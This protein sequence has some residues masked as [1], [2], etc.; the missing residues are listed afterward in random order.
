MPFM[1]L[2][3]KAHYLQATLN[4]KGT[5]PAVEETL[6]AILAHSTQSGGKFVFSETLDDSYSR[7]LASPLRTNCAILSTLTQTAGHSNLNK[8]WATRRSSWRVSSR[9][10]VA[11]ATTGRTRRRTCSA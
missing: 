10:H 2:F 6:D 7:I 4:I 1:S 5:L 9:R 3:G 8:N 11:R